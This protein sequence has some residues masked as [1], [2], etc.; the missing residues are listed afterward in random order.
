MTFPKFSIN[1]R[2]MLCG[3]MEYLRLPVLH[4]ESRALIGFFGTFILRHRWNIISL[5]PKKSR[6]IHDRWPKSLAILNII[7]W[8]IVGFELTLYC[9]FD[10]SLISNQIDSLW[11][12]IDIT[13]SYEY[14]IIVIANFCNHICIGAM[15]FFTVRFKL[16]QRPPR[17]TVH[18]VLAASTSPATPWKVTIWKFPDGGYPT[19]SSLELFRLRCSLTIHS[20]W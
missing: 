12:I 15:R 6:A 13:K 17:C 10:D 16:T 18:L 8:L 14:H 7:P 1:R 9:R 5:K 3:W 19:S 2:S 20:S 4:F 11:M